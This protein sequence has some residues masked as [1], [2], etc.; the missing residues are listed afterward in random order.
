MTEVRTVRVGG[1]FSG[2]G[3]HHSAVDRLNIPGVEFDD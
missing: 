1:F 2:I 3:S